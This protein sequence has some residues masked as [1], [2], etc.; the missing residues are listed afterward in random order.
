MLGSSLAD[1]AGVVDETVLGSILLGLQS[2]EE[3]F[4][5]TEDLNC[6]GRVLGQVE[7]GTSVGN[8]TSADKLTEKNS[9]VWSNGGH[10]VLKSV[11][12]DSSKYYFSTLRYS[13]SWA[14]YPVMST[15][16]SA[17]ARMFS[18]S[19]SLMSVPIETSASSLTCSSISSGRMSLKSVSEQFTLYLILM[20]V[21]AYA[22]LS[23]TTLPISG[24]CQPYHSRTRMM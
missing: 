5:S 19:S 14:L 4:F 7:E 6:R 2:S 15:T 24:K 18:K 9:Q 8:Q 12:E 20:I 1:H 17:R 22:R 16:C 10:S 11:F 23:V 3:S 21:L 13:K